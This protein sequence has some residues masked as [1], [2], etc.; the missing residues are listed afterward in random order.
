MRRASSGIHGLSP[1][2]RVAWRIRFRP[3]RIPRGLLRSDMAVS[4]GLLGLSNN[5]LPRTKT[6]TPEETKQAAAVMLAWADGKKIEW[7]ARPI[8]KLGWKPLTADTGE[9]YWNW[10]HCIY[11]IAPEPMEVDV[12]VHKDGGMIYH[13]SYFSSSVT[14]SAKGFSRRRAT[15]HPEEVSP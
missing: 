15:I 14:A 11:R 5:N 8:E 7:S 12:W 1:A 10:C 3:K 9:P 13:D 6:M 2:Y 4:S